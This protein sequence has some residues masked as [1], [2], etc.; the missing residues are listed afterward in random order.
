M[1]LSK[2]NYRQAFHFA[3]KLLSGYRAIW[4]E[5]AFV[6][7]ELSWTG[8]YPTLY[9]SL[10]NLTPEALNSLD[11]EEKLLAYLSTYIPELRTI[12]EWRV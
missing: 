2:E 12:S 5:S 6:K 1:L 11:R 3:D 8:D 4:S 10:L 7:E 9:E